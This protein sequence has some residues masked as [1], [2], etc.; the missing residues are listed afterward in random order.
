M[1]KEKVFNIIYYLLSMFAI[2]SL[3]YFYL[4]H[5]PDDFLRHIKYLDYKDLGGYAYMYPL[6]QFETF[7]FNPWFGF[8]LIVGTM[9]RL[10]GSD[11]TILV[12]QVVFACLF[13]IAITLNIRSSDLEEEK[14]YVGIYI[15]FVM[16]LMSYCLYRI[17]LIRPCIILA[18]L[19]L[20]SLR[21]K[22][23]IS[24]F[25]MASLSGFSYYLFFLYTIPLGIAHYLKGSKKFGIGVLAAT[26]AGIISWAFL[27][28]FEYFKVLGL[29]VSGLFSRDGV[30]ISENVISLAKITNLLIFISLILFIATLVRNFKLDIYL[31]LGILSLPL[32]Y[33][34]RYFLDITFPLIFIYIVRNNL[35]IKSFIGLNKKVFEVAMLASFLLLV[36]PLANR[37]LNG[38]QAIRLDG[39][40]LPKGSIVFSDSLATG[41]SAIYWNKEPV[42]IM[43][44]TEIGWSDKE[45]KKMLKEIGKERRV[46][47]DFCSYAEDRGITHL[48]TAHPV[49]GDCFKHIQ[50]FNKGY[51]VDLFHRSQPPGIEMPSMSTTEKRTKKCST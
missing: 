47:Q 39:I 14:E 3:I 46:S 27:T 11:N 10:I 25:L 44:A 36:P 7:S 48:I 21:G 31:T 40:N 13:F 22:G 34:A 51:R 32:A 8:D 16:V 50:T 45:T 4:P 35:D 26:V 2:G 18:I 38:D 9:N 17:L 29:I 6:S 43:P 20:I 30:A 37:A 23:V 12:Y 5:P 41:F 19:T 28:E 1:R 33:Q 42:R 49:E 24:G 15:L